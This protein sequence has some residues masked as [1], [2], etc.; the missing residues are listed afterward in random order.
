MTRRAPT[1]PP[2][3]GKGA[4][5]RQQFLDAA[6]EVFVE[7]GYA[8]TSVS[9]I[10]ARVGVSHGAFYR[11][12]DSK[13]D[14]LDAVI[15][16]G[17]ERFMSLAADD[18]LSDEIAS[19]DELLARLRELAGRAFALAEDEPGLV[20]LV[21]LEATSVDDE[22]SYRLLG[23]LDLLAALAIPELERA[24]RAGILRADVQADVLADAVVGMLVPGLVLAFRGQIDAAA[25]DRQV[26]A[27]VDLVAS[28]IRK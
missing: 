5:R 9:D 12:F 10:T 1:Q 19:A 14:I 13:R 4:R 28:G 24:K 6:L 22:L 21:M 18:G 20:R 8:A 2:S 17:L 27:F 7:Q 11:Y 25:R 23:L 16:D 3:G 26:D 15:D